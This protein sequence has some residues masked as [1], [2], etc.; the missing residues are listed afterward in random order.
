MR[1][2]SASSGQ[3]RPL[4]RIISV[5]AWEPG[6]GTSS[7][8]AAWRTELDSRTDAQKNMRPQ[9]AA[10]EPHVV[11]PPSGGTPLTPESTVVMPDGRQRIPLGSGVITSFLGQ[12]GMANVYEIWN[13]Q[14]EVYRAVKLINPNSNRTARERFQTEIKITAKLHHPNITEIYGVGHW[15]GLP[16]IEMEKLQGVGLDLL[17][18]ERGAMP[19]WVCTAVGIMIGRALKYAHGQEYTL[20][21][22]SYRGIIHRDLKPSN[23]MVCNNGTVKLM[24]FGIA[25]P[26]EASFHTVAG[27]ILGTLQYLAPE[28]LECKRLDHT[29]DIYALGTTMYEILT[30]HMAFSEPGI[31]KLML[32]KLKGRFKPLREYRV[33]APRRL[34]RLIQR[35]MQQEPSRRIQSA[36]ALLN[37]LGRIHSNLTSEP[38]EQVM[39]RLLQTPPSEKVVVATRPVWPARIAAGVTL[40]VAAGAGVWYLVPLV[41]DEIGGEAVAPAT[42]RST[43]AKEAVAPEPTVPAVPATNEN[44]PK[45]PSP[46]PQRKPPRVARQK[47]K[48]PEATPREDEP[49]P[50]V[51]SAAAEPVTPEPPPPQPKSFVEQM[52]QKHGVKDLFAVVKNEVRD[53]NHA[54]ALKVYEHLPAEQ[55]STTEALLFKMRALQGAGSESRLSAFLDGTTIQDGEYFLVKGRLAYKNGRY[56][57]ALQLL[58]K[59]LRAPRLLID[60]DHLKREVG[61]YRAMCATALFDREP[62]EERYRSAMEEWWQLKSLLR[63]EPNHAYNQRVVAETQRIGRAFREARGTDD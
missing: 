58:D 35:C 49:A 54:E 5:S 56:A 40:A 32:D 14:L 15:N 7:A 62:T 1:A 21:G 28:Q 38:P 34:K 53:G 8:S 60:Y 37:E 43:S 31:H 10:G 26:A 41:M 42:R 17:L 2:I 46:A 12:G 57:Q 16:Y 19:P 24:D 11:R 55:Q 51:A 6:V 47:P 18:H 52:Q 39:R 4:W 9:N 50:L 13:D 22:K 61:Y 29:S 59:S 45:K 63:A 30:G 48:T 3:A 23:I 27:T 20:Y 44:R 33:K 25:S 36:V